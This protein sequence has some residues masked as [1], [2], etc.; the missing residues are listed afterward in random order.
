[1]AAASSLSEW[2]DQSEEYLDFCLDISGRVVDG[3][4][5][6]LIPPSILKDFFVGFFRPVTLPNGDK[7]RIL[8]FPE[9]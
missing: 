6:Q 3:S 9:K 2:K 1:M 4:G 5:M 8:T 7:F